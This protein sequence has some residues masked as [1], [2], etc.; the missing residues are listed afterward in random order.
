MADR[1]LERKDN[2]V[3][4]KS[5]LFFTMIE[6]VSITEGEILPVTILLITYLYEDF[7]LFQPNTPKCCR[8]YQKKNF[9]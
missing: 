4:N 3:L 6:P 9:Y 1:F 7:N 2:H 5:V 8:C